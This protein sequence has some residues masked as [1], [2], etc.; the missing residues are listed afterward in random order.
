VMAMNNLISRG[1]RRALHEAATDVDIVAFDPDPDA[2]LYTPSPSTVVIDPEAAGRAAAGLLLDR[3]GGDR[4]AP[5]RVVLPAA[6]VMRPSTR[7]A[8]P[9]PPR[10]EP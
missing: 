3:L 2:E 9:P 6:L 4:R 8:P 5:R 7:P 10:E 1:V